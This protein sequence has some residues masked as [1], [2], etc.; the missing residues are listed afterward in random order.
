[1]PRRAGN[2]PKKQP[3][4][5]IDKRNGQKIEIRKSKLRR[6]DPPSGLAEWSQEVWE[7]YW[8]DPVSELATP[9]DRSLL[10]RWIGLVDRYHFMIGMAMREPEVRGS[11]GQKQVNGFFN[12]AAQVEGRIAAAEAQLGIGPKNRAAL[13]IAVLSEQ[14]SLSDL[15]REFED[16]TGELDGDEDEDPRVSVVRGHTER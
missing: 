8:D 1:M 12:A 5:A 4:V 2:A 9:A 7:T 3:G 10:V 6:F 14:R 11:T 15:N 16:G 13:G